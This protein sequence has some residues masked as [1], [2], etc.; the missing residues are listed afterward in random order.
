MEMDN[1]AKTITI[2]LFKSIELGRFWSDIGYQKLEN[3]E[4]LDMVWLNASFEIFTDR[5]FA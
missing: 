2:Q 3:I 4:P 5:N 1:T